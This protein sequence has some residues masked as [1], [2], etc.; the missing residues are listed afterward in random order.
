MYQQ[1]LQ[2]SAASVGAAILSL[3][4]AT[5]TTPVAGSSTWLSSTSSATTSSDAKTISVLSSAPDQVSGGDVR[6]AIDLP[7]GH[8]GS[9]LLL[10]G[11]LVFEGLTRDGNRVEGL[12]DGLVEGSNSLRV[13][14]FRFDDGRFFLDNGGAVELINHPITGPIFSGQQQQPFVCTVTSE[15]GMQ[16]MIDSSSPPGFRV[17]DADGNVMGYSTNCSIESFVTYHYRT[18]EDRWAD[19]PQ[20]GGMPDD[21]ATTMTIDGDEV[22][23]VVR[24]ERGT[25]NRFIYSHAMLVNPNSIGIE[26]AGNW[27][28]ERWNGR[29]LYHFQGGVGIGHTQG[30]WASSRAMNPDV[31]GLGH[32]ITYSTGNRTG[33]HYNLQVG[34]ETALMTKEHF[35]K[36]FGSPRYTV[37]LGGSGGGIQQYVYGQNHPGL[38]DAAIP[39]RS[40]PDMV[41]QTIHVSDCELLEHYMDVTDRDNPFWQTTM[42]RSLLVGFNSTDL[43]GNPFADAQRA[44]GY[45]AAPGMTE[46]V[47]A[48]RGLSPLALNPFFG[49]VPNAEQWEPLS[50]IFEIEWTHMDDLRHIYGT[51]ENGFARRAVDNVGVQFGLQAFVNGEIDAEQ[52][53]NLNWHAGGWKPTDEIVQE[54]FP[55]L[56]DPTPDNFDPWSRRNIMLGDS[57]N[58]APR[59]TGNLEA[60]SALYETGMIFRGQIG[61]PVLDIRDWLE[62]VLDMHNSHQSFAARQR[63]LNDMNNADHQLIWF[64]GIGDEPPFQFDQFN[65]TLTALQVMDQW[66]LNILDNP[67]AGIVANRPDDAVDACFKFDGSVI[68]AGDDVWSGILD[69]AEAGPCTQAFPTFT[70]SRIEAGGPITGDVFKCQLKPLDVALFDG[71]YGDMS[72]STEEADRLRRV[73]PDGVCDYSLPDAGRPDGL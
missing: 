49:Q 73:F 14:H 2:F 25:I 59:H 16:P 37:G 53:I 56:G 66:M 31:L 7:T 38:L 36:Q 39:Q 20:D 60:I 4:L 9:M 40:Y 51:D 28:T 19:W 3:G 70:T 10:N 27:D 11:D 21:L 8:L 71:T 67:E 30:G 5:V 34:G 15:F 54:G 47:P 24:V 48:W 50:D 44:L 61:I 18:T 29:L 64:A 35:I 62:P 12:I 17:M 52:F 42:N 22:E 26:S 72:F 43:L 63:I 58:P 41:T 23:F 13:W 6:V 55:F 69:D 57:E 46:C 1:F 32:A 45:A 68:A 33:E 65:L